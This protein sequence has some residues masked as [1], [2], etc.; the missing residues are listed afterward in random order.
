MKPLPKRRNAAV[1]VSAVALLALSCIFLFGAMPIKLDDPIKGQ[2]LSRELR[3]VFPTEGVTFNGV[4]RISIPNTEPREVPL[5]SK[6]IVGK[7]SWSSVY[8]AKMSSGLVETLTVRRFAEKPNEYEWSRGG[9]TQ[10]FSGEKATNS[11]AGSDFALLDLGLEFFHW[12]TQLLAMREM[13]KGRGCDVLESRPAQVS[14]YSRV[15]SWI[16][17]ESR[18]EGQPGLLMAEA[19]D[20]NGKVLKEFEIKGF[21]KGQVREMELRN[22]QTKTSTRLVFEIDEK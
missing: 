4:M 3:S 13:R 9:T 5:Q 2:K 12:P 1:A 7:E 10:K 20:R 16:D 15:L 21:K 6:V 18:A 11:F 22:R 14:F 17:Q 19:Y 8:T